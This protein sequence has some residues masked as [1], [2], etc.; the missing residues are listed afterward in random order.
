MRLRPLLFLSVVLLL[1][2]CSSNERR[3]HII[4]NYSKAQVQPSDSGTRVLLSE[5][6]LYEVTKEVTVSDKH[7]RL[8]EGGQ[9]WSYELPKSG[10][11]VINLLD[12]TLLSV[13]AT[14]RR[15]GFDINA[16]PV[17]PTHSGNATIDSM[18]A[19]TARAK[20]RQEAR[21]SE[22]RL[23]NGRSNLLTLL[24]GKMERVSANSDAR[25]FILTSPPAQVKGSNAD[26]F[27]YYEINRYGIFLKRAMDQ[28]RE[29]SDPVQRSEKMRREFNQ[30]MNEIDR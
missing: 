22:D 23:R 10:Q 21:A 2:A 18:T 27:E 20:E 3:V 9:T 12:D 24:P 13:P 6:G 15:A 5:P 11:Y 17:R 29:E 4:T 8:A 19:R 7:L 25:L 16:L 1:A 30:R 26:E 14:Y 28:L